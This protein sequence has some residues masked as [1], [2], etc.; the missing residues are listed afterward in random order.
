MGFRHD[1]ACTQV[2]AGGD[3]LQVRRVAANILDKQWQTAEKEWSSSMDVGQGANNF[4]REYV[5]CHE[6]EW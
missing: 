5:T 3:G 6:T 1:M 2:A 4:C